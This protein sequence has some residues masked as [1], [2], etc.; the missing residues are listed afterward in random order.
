MAV[1]HGAFVKP[2]YGC[3]NGAERHFT[4]RLVR[5]ASTVAPGF[6]KFVAGCGMTLLRTG[7]TSLKLM[8]RRLCADL[9]E[10]RAVAKRD[11]S[12]G[13][14]LLFNLLKTD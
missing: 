10:R 5:F 2:L 1:H 13:P 7:G 6:N 9:N 4:A 14:Q 3:A 11:C 12:L 8:T